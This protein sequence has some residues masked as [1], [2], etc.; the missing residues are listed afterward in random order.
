[1]AKPARGRRASPSRSRSGSSSRSYSGSSSRSR[2][3]SRSRS[4]SSSSSP[5]R[6]GSSRSPSPAPPR[7]SP[8][9]DANRGRLPP[10]PPLPQ[11]KKSPPLPR[12]ASPVSESL[13]LHVDQLSRNV[14]ENHLKEIFGNF[15]EVLN[16]RLAIDHVVNLPK[17]FAYV[18]FK[19]RADAEKAQLYMDGAQV[20]GKVIRVKF[21]LPERKKASSPPKAVA[22]SSS[23][24][25]P[26]SN[27]AALDA[28]KPGPKRLKEVSPRRKPLSPPRRRSPRRG[29]DSHP[30][31]RRHADSPHRRGDSPPPRRRP[32]SPAR[33]RSP[34]SPPRHYNRSSPRRIRGSPV[35]HRSPLPPRRRSPVGRRHSRSPIRRPARSRSRS[36]SPRRGRGPP[37]RR[38][39][40]SSYSS[41][42]SPRRVCFLY[43]HLSS[44]DLFVFLFLILP[45]SYEFVAA[46]TE[47]ITE[48]QS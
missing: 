13:V 1:M 32:A 25:A 17:G 29:L 39:R 27:D 16:V 38:G 44:V 35:R 3:R 5:S 46:T 47:G 24:D 41:S 11:A 7:K 43:T 9:E 34:T 31:P 28:D 21:T 26:K 19:G 36:L 20:D 18:E 30:P 8:R 42:P 23:R 45:S 48:P 14:N 10:P 2:S 12:K 15:C 40:L 33:G 22:T 37:A 6:S 4:F